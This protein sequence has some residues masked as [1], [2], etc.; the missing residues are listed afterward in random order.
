MSRHYTAG[1]IVALPRLDAITVGRL[2]EE[3][4]TAA[5]AEKKLPPSVVEARDEMAE[6]REGLQVELMRR[7][8]GEG[9]DTPQVRAADDVEDNAFRA[10]IG[11]L[12]AVALLPADRHP[13]SAEAQEILDTVFADGLAFINIRP[14]KEWEEA[15]IRLGLL[16][17]R[18]YDKTIAKLGG[19][20]F[21]DELA[22][23]HGKYGEALGI[24]TIP[25]QQ[26]PPAVRRRFL[27]AMESVR[28]YVLRVTA[29]ISRKDPK[30]AELAERLLKPLAEWKDEKP[31]AT[32]AAKD[33]KAGGDKPADGTA[34]PEAGT[35][36]P[37]AGAA[38]SEAGSAKPAEG[39]QEKKVA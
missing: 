18:G 21:L 37:E 6:A 16:E 36:K 12:R 17:S 11:F 15:N 20:S 13:E 35:A 10:L 39:T 33:A 26:V 32:K 8:A 23:A 27:A 28:T 38:K 9:E 2:I 29:H 3:L 22:Y 4:R 24:S 30:T 25:E 19:Q 1:S 31:K 14:E 5:D 34:K 7:H